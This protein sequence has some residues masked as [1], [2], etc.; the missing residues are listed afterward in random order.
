MQR[1]ED[2]AASRAGVP[3]LRSYEARVGRPDLH[4]GI[5]RGD[6]S[7][8]ANRL[9]CAHSSFG[10]GA[11]DAEVASLEVILSTAVLNTL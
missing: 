6:A 1:L 11:Y 2:E 4:S 3:L 9:D 10:P 8:Q 5:Q 7:S